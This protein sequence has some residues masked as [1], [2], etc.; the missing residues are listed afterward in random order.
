M[1]FWEGL[2][3]HFHNDYALSLEFSIVHSVNCKYFQT[4]INPSFYG[5]KL[6]LVNIMHMHNR[7]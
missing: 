7:S 6:L 3:Q 5:I 1:C 2:C 4:R